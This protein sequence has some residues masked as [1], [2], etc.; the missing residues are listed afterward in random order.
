MKLIKHDSSQMVFKSDSNLITI[1]FML[2]WGSLFAGIPLFMALTIV[3][4]M[5]AVSLAC[6]RG[7]WNQ[8]NCQISKSKFF[9]IEPG[10]SQKINAILSAKHL[11]SQTKDSDGD[12][13]V[14]H[15]VIFATKAGNVTYGESF[16]YLNGVRGNYEDSIFIAN[17]ITQ[18]LGARD[19]KLSITKSLNFGMSQFFGLLFFVPFL[20]FGFGAIFFVLQTSSLILDKNLG[21]V[22]RKNISL[23]GI[24][25][26]SFPLANA[27]KV[28]IQDYTDSYN[29]SYFTPV[30]ILTSGEKFPLERVGHRDKA[31]IMANQIR[32][33]LYLPTESK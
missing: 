17:Q 3:E 10:E 22:S 6:D 2:L 15:R 25:T 8:V 1:I 29:N 32:L 16:I 31:L 28:E 13:M 24:R 5:G 12:R 11:I 26:K 23:L 18:F 20:L 27:N 33:F 14:D 9:G 19:L 7:R 30:I 4:D 21:K